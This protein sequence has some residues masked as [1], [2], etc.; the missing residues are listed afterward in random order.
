MRA[1]TFIIVCIQLA[2]FVAGTNQAFSSSTPSPASARQGSLI[3][4]Q[5]IPEDS[6]N[7]QREPFKSPENPKLVTGSQVKQD[8]PDLALQ[9]I[10]KVSKHYYAIINGRTTKPGDRIEGWTI[11][12]ISRYRV[13]LRREKERQIF[14]IYQG[15]IDRGNR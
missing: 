13:T 7:W 11:V 2:L 12:E 14:D 5:S 8:S 10:M 4:W 9:G 1:K 6:A 15:K 3:Q